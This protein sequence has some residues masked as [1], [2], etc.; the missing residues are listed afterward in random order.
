MDSNKNKKIE[1]QVDELV[2]YID[3]FMSKSNAGHI[4]VK[5]NSQGE[6]NKDELFVDKQPNNATIRN[7][8]NALF[9]KAFSFFINLSSNTMIT[10]LKKIFKSMIHIFINIIA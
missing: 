1:Q 10:H 3:N 2:N 7:N 4:N 5:V 6:I 8:A 9:I